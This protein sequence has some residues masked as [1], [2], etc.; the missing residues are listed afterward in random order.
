MQLALRS[1]GK[2]TPTTIVKE[3]LSKRMEAVLGVTDIEATCMFSDIEGFTSV[4][5]RVIPSL[6]IKVLEDYFNNMTEII[7][8][9]QGTVGDFIGDAIFAFF[10]APTPVGPRHAY[11]CVEAALK[12]QERL[13]QLR[14]KW[15]KDGWPELRARIGINSGRCLAGNVGSRTRLKFTLI[16]DSVNLAARL[17]ALGKYYGSYLTMSQNTLRQ[18]G[19]AMNFCV[20]VL[21]TVR[22][23]GKSV[24]CPVLEVVCRRPQ[25]TPAQLEVER[26]SFVMMT[27]YM[28][29]NLAECLRVLNNM[30]ELR[31][32]DMAIHSMRD[33]VGKLMDEGLPKNWTGIATMSEK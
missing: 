21:D 15:K 33:R 17:E 27:L 16:G 30:D 4:S 23:V 14:A 13:V 9:A 24:P 12:Q 18:P 3:M 31:P 20:R 22:V 11:M 19:V 25:A 8:E 1:F 10:G 29:G 6:L 26:L 32:D 2:F 5:E 28:E 7:E